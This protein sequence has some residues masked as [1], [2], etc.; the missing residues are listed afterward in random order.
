MFVNNIL[1]EYWNHHKP[2]GASTRNSLGDNTDDAS[3]KCSSRG[4]APC[5]ADFTSKHAAFDDVAI[6]PRTFYSEDNSF[7]GHRPG[8]SWHGKDVFVVTW[9][10]NWIW[11]IVATFL[12]LG[13]VIR[14]AYGSSLRKIATRR[15]YRAHGRSVYKHEA[16][17]IA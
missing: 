16:E 3:S 1:K 17:Y 14:W 10:M 11:V 6:L 13:T 8:G 15:K 9:L 4:K 5:K 7:F 12:I 2:R